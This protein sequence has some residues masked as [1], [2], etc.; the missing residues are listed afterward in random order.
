MPIT[1]TIDKVLASGMAVPRTWFPSAALSP[2]LNRPKRVSQRKNQGD[3]TGRENKTECTQMDD[4]HD[5]MLL[6]Q[7]VGSHRQEVMAIPVCLQQ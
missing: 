1:K 4:I 7:E 5:C 2:L 6:G 3:V